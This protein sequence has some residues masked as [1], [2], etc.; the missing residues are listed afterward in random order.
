MRIEDYGL[1]GDCKTASLI[2]RN[3][4][5]DWLCWP[6]F[7]GAACFAAL[8]G[9]AKHGRWSIVPADGSCSTSR[10]YRGDTMVL[11]TLFE[12]ADG[13]FAIIDFM[14]ID[15]PHSS[16]IRVVEGRRGRVPV[17]MSLTLRFDYGSSIPWVTRLP[18]GD[19]IVAIAGPSLA[20]LRTPVALRGEDLSTSADFS[21]E[22]GERVPFVLTYASLIA[23]RRSPSMSMQRCIRRRGFGAIGR[24]DAPIKGSG[25]RLFC[26]HC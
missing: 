1:V 25:G 15:Q 16:L 18:D 23:R 21:V 20:V 26:A 9:S 13:A 2:G 5:V 12:T 3:G 24:R 10:S 4:S 22:V 6:R 7:D 11:E 14:P 19:G 17:R 8:L